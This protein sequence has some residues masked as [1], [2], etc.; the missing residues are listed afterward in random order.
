[1]AK[2]TCSIDGCEGLNAGH[3]WCK[4][5]YDKWYL[6]GDPLWERPERP[7][8]CSID[9]CDRPVGGLGWCSSHYA[10][11]HKYGDPVRPLAYI[12][13]NDEARFWQYVDKDGASGCWLWT[14][15][16]ISNGYGRFFLVRPRRGDLAHRYNYEA[17]VGP[18]PD[19][20]D[21]RP[22]V[23]SPQLRRS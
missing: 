10:R 12:R 2:A 19:C 20:L 5:H 1:M 23:P 8:F 15:Y 13:G 6:H 22:P 18:I 14:G 4:R 3:G 16:K 21:L 11:W 9:G 7:K 17:L